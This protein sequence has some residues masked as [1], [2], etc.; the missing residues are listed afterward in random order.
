MWAEMNRSRSS[1]IAIVMFVVGSV[2]FGGNLAPTALAATPADRSEVVLVFDLS[3]SILV[4][5]TNRGRFAAALDRIA[6][7]VDETSADLVVG[8]A[9]VS[10]VQDRKSVV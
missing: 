10:I 8:D 5:A 9:T 3:A 7:R 6:A 1:S 4:D 2:L